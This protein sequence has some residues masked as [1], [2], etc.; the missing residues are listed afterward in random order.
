MNKTIK[1]SSLTWE[2]L[3]LIAKKNGNKKPEDFVEHLIQE[4]YN[5]MKK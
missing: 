4:N 3:V 1:V 2:M 5:K